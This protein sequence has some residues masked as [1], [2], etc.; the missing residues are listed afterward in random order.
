MR[1]AEADGV[2]VGQLQAPVQVLG[3][4]F[5]FP[6]RHDTMLH[7]DFGVLVDQFVRRIEGSRRALR[8]VSDARAA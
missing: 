8:H 7:R 6:A 3:I 4:R 2:R 1:I 5:R